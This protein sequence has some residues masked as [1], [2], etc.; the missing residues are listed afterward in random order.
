MPEGDSIAR[1]AARLRPVLADHRLVRFEAP[2]VP[3]PHPKAGA[4][5]IAV[6]SYGK[7]LMI[8]F[9]DGFVLETHLRMTGRWDLYAPGERWR[10]PTY[11]ARA[12]VEVDD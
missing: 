4:T 9:D 1:L 10:K 3:P 6:D 2:R 7:Y 8:S 12:I 5:V 11:L